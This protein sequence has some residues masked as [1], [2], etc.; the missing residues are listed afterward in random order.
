MWDEFL[1]NRWVEWANISIISRSSCQTSQLMSAD[2]SLQLRKETMRWSSHTH[3]HVKERLNVKL[4]GTQ[5]ICL[6]RT[7][8]SVVQVKCELRLC[9]DNIFRQGH[10]MPSGTN[11]SFLFISLSTWVLQSCREWMRRRRRTSVFSRHLSDARSHS[12]RQI[13]QWFSLPFFAFRLVS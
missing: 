7:L 10:A 4:S 12:L 6:M 2:F 11:A 5:I 13:D 9:S 3:A 1:P 8:P